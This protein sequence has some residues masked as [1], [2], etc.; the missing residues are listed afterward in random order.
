MGIDLPSSMKLFTLNWEGVTKS[1]FNDSFRSKTRPLRVKLWKTKM[2]TFLY[3]C[4]YKIVFFIMDPEIQMKRAKRL[5]HTNFNSDYPSHRISISW[6][7]SII[8]VIA[9]TVKYD[10]LG[11]NQN[12]G[13]TFI[14]IHTTFCQV[15]YYG[16]WDID[17]KS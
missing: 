1:N 15:S 9:A 14:H 7:K 6:L 8:S 12:N 16:S 3:W 17:E 11:E 10:L 2:T 5:I 4:S 13:I